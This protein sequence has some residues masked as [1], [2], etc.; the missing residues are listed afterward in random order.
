VLGFAAAAA[1]TP[2]AAASP[3][4]AAAA[5]ADSGGDDD[6]I[7][8]LCGDDDAAAKAAP[9]P[10]AAK[11][12]GVKIA[13]NGQRETSGKG[14]WLKVVKEI[15]HFYALCVVLFWASCCLGSLLRGLLRAA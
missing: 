8:D 4:A 12:V 5:T 2:A 10:P 9:P 13:L 6:G 15:G 11:A 7:V 14:K 1:E 3:A